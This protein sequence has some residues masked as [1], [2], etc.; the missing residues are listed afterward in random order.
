MT[1]RL[2]TLACIS[3]LVMVCTGC[4][5]ATVQATTKP[6]TATEVATFDEPWAMAFL[7]D[8]RLL[9]TEKK[10]ALKLL[11][12]G[13][14]AGNISGVPKVAYGGRVAS[15][16]SRCIRSSPTTILCMSATPRKARAARVALR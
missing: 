12:I 13:G 8:G 7:P 2:S 16:M 15:V 11:A 9:V 4:N 10:G 6:F 5:G 3:L 1:T 14:K